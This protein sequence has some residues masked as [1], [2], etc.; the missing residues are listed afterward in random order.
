MRCRFA[1]CG[2]GAALLFMSSD[3][4][5]DLAR[6]GAMRVIVTLLWLPAGNAQWF[7]FA[8]ATTLGMPFFA[9]GAFLTWI[10][11]TAL[12]STPIAALTHGISVKRMWARALR[13]PRTWAIG[14]AG[15]M[16]AAVVRSVLL[17]PLPFIAIAM[18]FPNVLCAQLL[19]VIDE[20]QAQLHRL[21]LVRD[22]VQAM[23]GDRDPLPQINAILTTLRVPLFDETVTIFAATGERTDSWR[24]VT[25]LG[26]PP[27]P[28]GEELRTRILARLKFSDQ[29]MTMLR[30][31]YYTTYAFAARGGDELHGAMV[32]HRRSALPSEAGD[33]VCEGC[34][35]AGA[36]AARHTIGERLRTAIALGGQRYANGEPVTTSI[37]VA[38]VKIGEAPEALLA[39]ADRALYEAKRLGRNRI[40]EDRAGT[41]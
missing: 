7:V 19:R 6:H 34:K 41:A 22:A 35:R 4:R 38:M 14:I 9:A 31:E 27:S 13:D 18:W 12:I 10:A 39:R 36:V 33:A 37:G 21:R 29:P 16:W 25:T 24:T 11:Y 15:A 3:A 26:P 1:G 32:V 2:F 17:H 8:T 40:S 20:Q 28:A 23:L 5:A 30:N